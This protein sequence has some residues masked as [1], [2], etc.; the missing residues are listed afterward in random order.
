MDWNNKTLH[1]I[2]LVDPVDLHE[3]VEDTSCVRPHGASRFDEEEEQE[4]LG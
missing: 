1:L 2:S 3:L 4:T